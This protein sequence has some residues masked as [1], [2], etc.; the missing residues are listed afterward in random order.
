[1]KV[2]VTHNSP[3]NRGVLV[4]AVGHRERYSSPN[5][6][7]KCR[8][9]SYTKF[10]GTIT[11]KRRLTAPFVTLRL[12][13]VIMVFLRAK[14]VSVFSTVLCVISCP[15]LASPRETVVSI[16]KTEHSVNTAD[17]RSASKWA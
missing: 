3:R 2:Y 13:G 12:P 6:E 15:I 8:G 9:H 4:L 5:L 16:D 1:M 17:F 7:K 11:Q 10:I 14:V